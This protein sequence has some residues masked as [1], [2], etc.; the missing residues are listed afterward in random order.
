M[1]GT[2]AKAIRKAVYGDQSLRQKRQY[3]QITGTGVIWNHPDSLRAKYQQAKE[4]SE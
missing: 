2:K 4:G 1:R 3:V